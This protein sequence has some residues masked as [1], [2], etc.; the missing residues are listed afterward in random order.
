M[1]FKVTNIAMTTA[2]RVSVTMSEFNADETGP[3]PGFGAGDRSSMVLNL[4]VDESRDY[5]VGDVYNVT[6]KAK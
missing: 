3:F 5:S 4:S 6:V 2:D 1:E